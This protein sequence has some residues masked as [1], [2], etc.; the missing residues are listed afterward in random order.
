VTDV[1]SAS[2]ATLS[3]TT[4][5][6]ALADAKAAFVAANP[7]S[8]AHFEAAA[9]VMPGGNTR[10]V[11]FYDPFPLCIARGEGARLWDVDGHAYLDFLGEFTAGIFGHS[12]PHIRAAIDAALDAGINL[13]GHNTLE[14]ELAAIVCQR[15]PSIE[16]VRFTNSGTE[17]NLLALAAAIVHTGR[18]KVLVFDCAY[19]GGVLSFGHGSAPVNVPHDYLMAPYNDL[20]RT[21]EIIRRHGDAIAAILVE[22]ML[23]AG[24]C[25]AAE[26]AF[27]AGLRA[28]ASRHGIV[29]IFDEVMT[30]RLSPGGRQSDLGIAPDM[31]TLGK[32]IGGGSSFGAFGGRAEIKRRFDPREPGALSHAGTFNNNVISMAAGIAG[33]TKVLT[34][35]AI[36]ALNARGD[37]LRD[38]L[39][40]MFRRRGA[41]LAATGLG[42]IVGLHGTDRPV[43]SPGD[44]AAA[45]PAIKDLVFFDLVT[46]GFYIARRGF[47]ALSLPLTDADTAGL[48][49]ALDDIVASRGALLR[50]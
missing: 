22:P 30:S 9:R 36:R 27:L 11:L 4:M 3:N 17:A 48:V 50:T 41:K 39:N 43:R 20:A 34:P 47:M 46:R 24:G 31:T 14:A 26:P 42:S 1:P 10:T 2:T 37:A 13:S 7:E 23:G 16:Q 44:A 5:A 12:N 19:H 21:E 8:R 28:A 40:T 33:M 35:E 29:L 18:K 15:F 45:D 6:A 38:A 25:I 49:A 32:Y